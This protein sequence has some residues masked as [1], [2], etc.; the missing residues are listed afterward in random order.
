MSSPGRLRRKGEATAGKEAEKPRPRVEATLK[1]IKHAID[2]A[3][4]NIGANFGIDCAAKDSNFLKLTARDP[5]IRSGHP[6][7]RPPWIG[8]HGLSAEQRHKRAVATIPS[9]FPRKAIVRWLLNVLRIVPSCP[10]NSLPVFLFIVQRSLNSVWLLP[11]TLPPPKQQYHC[12]TKSSSPPTQKV[13]SLTVNWTV[14]PPFQNTNGRPRR[15]FTCSFHTS[16][17]IQRHL[18][19]PFDQ[20][21]QSS[22]A[23]KHRC[24]APPPLRQVPTAIQTYTSLLIHPPLLRQLP[25]ARRRIPH[26]SSNNGSG[27]HRPSGRTHPCPNHPP[28]LTTTPAKTQ[29]PDRGREPVQVRLVMSAEQLSIVDKGEPLAC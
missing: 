27:T 28:P 7:S 4:R 23:I 21:S 1:F 26:C 6:A 2:S 12:Q 3:K 10:A 20:D 29:P 5:T 8:H 14:L 22:T 13:R 11:L 19:L 9:L 17:V 18:R 25:T 15:R 24:S 16:I